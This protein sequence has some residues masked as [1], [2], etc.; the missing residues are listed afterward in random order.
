MKRCF[1]PFNTVYFYAFTEESIKIVDRRESRLRF[2][3]GQDIDRLPIWLLTPFHPLGCYADVYRLPAAEIEAQVKDAVSQIMDSRLILSPT[4]G[5]Y[6][7]HPNDTLI[8]NYLPFLDAGL[9]YGK[10]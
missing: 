4:A 10:R 1:W 5:P 3:S 6:E 2:F 8:R 7:E 9:K